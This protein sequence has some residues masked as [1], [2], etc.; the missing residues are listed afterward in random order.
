MVFSGLVGKSNYFKNI[1][2]SKAEREHLVQFLL[3]INR[4]TEKV[5]PLHGVLFTLHPWLNPLF[6]QSSVYSL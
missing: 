2:S 3:S 4:F 5:F 6:L 1:R